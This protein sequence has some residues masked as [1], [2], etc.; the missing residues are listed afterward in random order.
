[1]RRNDDIP[2]NGWRGIAQWV[3]GSLGSSGRAP[4]SPV[5]RLQEASLDAPLRGCADRA[6]PL[7]P[8]FVD[9]EADWREC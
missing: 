9:T 5:A 8:G 4:D 6:T 2:T 3:L 7:P 1:M